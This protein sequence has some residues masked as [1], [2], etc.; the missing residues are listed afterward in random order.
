MSKAPIPSVQRALDKGNYEQSKSNPSTHI[1]RDT[2][3]SVDVDGSYGKK[4]RTGWT[5]WSNKKSI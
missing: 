4:K 1:N 3:E 2:G 5:N